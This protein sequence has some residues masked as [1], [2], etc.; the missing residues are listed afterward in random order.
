MG[1]CG[2]KMENTCYS[3]RGQSATAWDDCEDSEEESDPRIIQENEINYV[4]RRICRITHDKQTA[5][6]L[7]LEVEEKF[8]NKPNKWVYDKVLNDL[9][10]DHR[11]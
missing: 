3:K 6:R 10:R 2:S 11:R 5:H 8:P 7:I 9:L 4:Y 1:Y